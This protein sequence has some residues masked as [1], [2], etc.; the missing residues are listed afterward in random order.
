MQLVNSQ[1]VTVTFHLKTKRTLRRSHWQGPIP[2]QIK[3]GLYRIVWRCSYYTE[4]AMPLGAASIYLF[5]CSWFRCLSVSVYAP[6]R[7]CHSCHLFTGHHKRYLGLH[8]HILMCKILHIFKLFIL[9][10]L[11]HNSYVHIFLYISFQ[12]TLIIIFYLRHAENLQSYRI[13]W[14]H[15]P[16][17]S[18]HFVVFQFFHPKKAG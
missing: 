17:T 6:V 10:V 13:N 4:S 12:K 9:E 7:F 16:C 18:V 11:L 5:Y 14:Q 3:N 1:N 15:T 2:R 8:F